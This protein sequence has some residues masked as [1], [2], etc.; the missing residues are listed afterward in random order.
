MDEPMTKARLLDELRA[1]RAEWDALMLEE[2]GKERMLEPNVAGYWSVRDL[3]AHLTSYDRWFVNA[4]E[5]HFRGEPPP[6][7][8]TEGMD[9]DERNAIH[10]ERTKNLSLDEV[11]ADSR[12]TYNRLLEMV[13]AHSEEFLIQPQQLPGSPE[14]FVIWEQLRGNHYDHYR[15]HMKD[16]RA[17][18]AKQQQNA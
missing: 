3:I 18:L 10:H 15:L 9:W 6:L 5:A 13:E 2:V 1:A 4:S 8:G 11:L 16:V 17:W 7:D 12:T 14:P